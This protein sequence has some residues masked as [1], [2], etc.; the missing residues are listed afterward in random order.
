MVVT[1]GGTLASRSKNRKLPIELLC[2]ELMDCTGVQV[3]VVQHKS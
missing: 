1:L 2:K 3:Q